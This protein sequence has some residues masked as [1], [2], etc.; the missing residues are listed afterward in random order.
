MVK[1]TGFAKVRTNFD[2]LKYTC[3]S[4]SGLETFHFTL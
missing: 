3:V 1:H 4:E 2:L